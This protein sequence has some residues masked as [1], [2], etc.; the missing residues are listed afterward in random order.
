[1]ALG[2]LSFLVPWMLAVLAALPVLW[3]LLRLTPPSP[4]RIRFPAIR[5]LFGLRPR[6]ETPHRTPWWLILL[7]VCVAG[8]IILALAH[9]VWNAGRD[10]ARGGQVL[11]VIDNGWA[12]APHWPTMM[13]AAGDIVDRADREGRTIYLLP[14]ALVLGQNAFSPPNGLAPAQAKSAL[15]GL[16]PQA[17]PADRALATQALIAWRAANPEI[18]RDLNITWLSDGVALPGAQDADFAAALGTI[19]HLEIVAPRELPMVLRPA[20]IGAAEMSV[21]L[22]RAMVGAAQ[23]VALRLRDQEGRVI[24]TAGASFAATANATEA[25]IA[26]PLELRGRIGAIAI[27]DA[28]G[29]NTHAAA[30]TLL[31]DSVGSRPVGVITDNPAAA[32]QPLLGELYYVERALQPANELRVGNA[33]TLLGQSLAVMILPDSTALSEADRAALERWVAGGGMLIRFAGQRLAVNGNDGDSLLPVHLRQGD[34]VL[35]GALSWSEPTSLAPF[36]ANSP[37]AGLAIPPEV[38]VNRQVLAEPDIELGS[39]TWARLGDGTPLVTGAKTGDGYKVLFHVSA[40]AEWSDLAL[41]GLFVEMLERLLQL[42]AGMPQAAAEE[43]TPL[44]PS[45]ILDGYGRLGPAPSSLTPLPPATLRD[46]AVGPQHPPGL[47]GPAKGRRALNLGAGLPPVTPL[48]LDSAPLSASGAID[49]KPWLLLLAGLLLI[50]DGIVSLLL[51]GLVGRRRQGA[52]L[53]TGAA[54]A[55]LLLLGG[56]AFQPRAA[57]AQSGTR[58]IVQPMTDEEIIAATETTRLAYVRTGVPTVDATSRAGLIG[59][60]TI[61]IER[62]STDV[63]EPVGIDL[64]VDTLDFYPVLYWPIAG[65]GQTLNE[66]AVAGINRYIAGGGLILFDT[67]DQNITGIGG[68]MGPG[69][70]RLQEL[71]GG[72]DIPPLVPVG[73]DHVLT[74]AF[75]LLKDFPGRWVGGTLWVETPQT[76]VNDGVASVIVGSNDFAAA[77]AID[78]YGQ[79]M[80]PV[81]PGGERQREIAYRF[82]V[83]LVMYALTGNYKS[84][85]VHVPAI[86]ERLGQ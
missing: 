66:H 74:R 10:F 36:P 9:P 63:G 47:Y 34:R 32:R 14:T 4:K 53:G 1:M 59:L 37:F 21:R 38:K 86:L 41:S 16:A 55:L 43:T 64:N 82:G 73:G 67:A 46:Q 61:L 27:D 76:R 50:V 58:N 30:L 39:R 49:W 12:A 35:G 48:A 83:N 29:D 68:G 71:A 20:E 57:E 62:T 25:K 28:L 23:E 2:N 40:N 24:G 7:R 33:E 51:R 75:Y 78:D 84:D 69:V 54:L 26:L 5:L 85:Q 11:I 31:D 18:A 80:F 6:E 60:T 13:N 17:W 22:E 65:T 44:P 79:P 19:G 70:M 81:T 3:W 42:A 8:F 56:T 15:A 77:W 45:Q 72:L 52:A